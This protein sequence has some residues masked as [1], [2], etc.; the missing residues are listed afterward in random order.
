M[1]ALWHYLVYPLL[2]GAP[3]GMGIGEPPF[4]DRGNLP[5]GGFRQGLRISGHGPK[6][7][8]VEVCYAVARINLRRFDWET[9]PVVS[10]FWDSGSTIPVSW[11]D[12]R[13]SNRA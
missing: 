5:S 9:R 13:R 10:H 2:A 8:V 6:R 1:T 7:P 11:I 4:A 12:A 3:L